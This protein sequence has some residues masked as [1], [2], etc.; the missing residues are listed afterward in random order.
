MICLKAL[1]EILVKRRKFRTYDGNVTPGFSGGKNFDFSNKLSGKDSLAPLVT[2]GGYGPDALLLTAPA[3][4]PSFS[5]LFPLT[6]QAQQPFPNN[7][8]HMGSYTFHINDRQSPTTKTPVCTLCSQAPG[9]KA[10]QRAAEAAAAMVAE[11]VTAGSGEGR[12]IDGGL[13]P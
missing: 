13:A 11:V 9:K 8:P 7:S 2:F 4:T 5:M 12:E 3:H 1:T 6:N 10:D